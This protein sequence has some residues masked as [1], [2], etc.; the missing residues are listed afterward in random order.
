MNLKTLTPHLAALVIFLITSFVIFGPEFQNKTLRRGDIM[1]YQGAAEEMH[2]YGREYDRR[3]NWTGTSFAGMPT[4]QIS[5]IHQGNQLIRVAPVLR[6]FMSG[7]AGAFFAG[8][9]CAYLLLIV[10]GVSPWL[11]IAGAVGIA[12]ATNNI[13]LWKA[14][15]ATKVYTVM[16]LPLIAAGILTAFNRK[17]L[18]GGLLFALGMGLAIFVNHPQMLYYFGMTIP[19][20]GL[21]KLVQAV[22][23]KQ[24]PHFA[25]A[26]GALLVGLVLAIGAGAN[27]LLPTQEY[28]AATMRGGQVLE[29]P[30]ASSA[31]SAKSGNGLDWEYA[32]G[33]SNGFKDMVATYAPLAAGGGGATE[34]STKTEFGKALK[35]V[36]PNLP[37]TFGAPM[38][39]GAL[40]FTEGPSYLGA[41]AWALFLF[42]LFNA[43]KPV[44]IWLGA[45][46]LLILMVSAGK[47]AE[48]FNRL[49]YDNL[50]LLNKF[51]T[52]NSALSISAFM[53]LALGMLGLHNWLRVLDRE[54]EKART[55]LLYSGITA[56]ALGAFI[57]ILLPA[58][59]D[60][61]NPNDAATLERFTGGQGDIAP[62]LDGLEATRRALYASDA[63]RSFLY[64]GLT[65]GTLFLLYRKTIGP[66]IAGLLLTGLLAFDYGGINGRYLDKKDWVPERSVRT[67]Y[68]KTAADDQILQDTDI[69]YRVFNLTAAFRAVQRCGYQLLPPQRRRL[70][71]RQDAPLP[72]HHRRLPLEAEHER[73]EYAQY[74]VLHHP[75]AG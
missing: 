26:T 53:M 14:G 54:P 10:V 64:V 12:L 29:N 21:A 56:A 46:T 72:R 69:H 34:V 19:L 41:V 11:S 3:M 50:P 55:R 16:Y 39:H 22:R 35:R 49:L 18:F 4:Y 23:Q 63:W 61:S 70:L 60:F 58:F 28:A 9:L 67:P 13:V 66:L 59:L 73:V 7:G 32:M 38:Y 5:N 20:F 47:N 74:E 24:L 71:R 8:M 65:F 48:G 57:A 36:I 2:T 33:W 75:R 1:A 6:G 25:K 27:N 52:P 43:R 31:G 40:P 62:L 37:A 44:A 15:H 51:R 68:P 17:Y 30:V 45:G 42:G